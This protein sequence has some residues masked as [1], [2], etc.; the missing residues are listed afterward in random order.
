[1]NWTTALSD[2]VAQKL[3]QSS[4]RARR[5]L[6]ASLRLDKGDK[7]FFEDEATKEKAEVMML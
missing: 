6:K 3:A 7:L 5:F 2:E 1:L 4:I